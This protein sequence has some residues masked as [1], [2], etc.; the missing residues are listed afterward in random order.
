MNLEG[1]IY[2]FCCLKAAHNAAGILLCGLKGFKAV[3]ES[4]G[5]DKWV[6]C[7]DFFIMWFI[8]AWLD[9]STVILLVGVLIFLHM[10]F[11]ELSVKFSRFCPSISF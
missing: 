5:L 6:L 11:S 9:G 7:S 10:K 4:M 8:V 1:Y 2:R 3:Y